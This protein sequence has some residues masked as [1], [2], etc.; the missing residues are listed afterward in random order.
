M[1]FLRR[2]IIRNHN[3][4]AISPRP[5]DHDKP[6]PGVTGG[7]LNDCCAWVKPTRFLSVSDNSVSSAIFHRAGGIHEFRF[8]ENL[9]TGQFRHTSQSNQWRVPNV[10]I[11]TRMCRTHAILNPF[12]KFLRHFSVFD[13]QFFLDPLFEKLLHVPSGK[14]LTN[15]WFL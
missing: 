4:R 15:S 9:T 14:R 10:S 11:D 1:H 7:S 6:D 8:S 2:L 13:N 5:P 3:H 12:A